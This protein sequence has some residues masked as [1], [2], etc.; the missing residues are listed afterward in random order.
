VKDLKYVL[1]SNPFLKRGLFVFVAVV[2]LTVGVLAY[3]ARGHISSKDLH[4]KI[5]AYERNG[6][7]T[8]GL[9]E[10]SKV[11]E[12]ALSIPDQEDLAWYRAGCYY[13]NQDFAKAHAQVTV[14]EDLY[15]RDTP[16][17]ADQERLVEYKKNLTLDETT[18]KTQAETNQRIEQDL[19]NGKKDTYNGP[20]L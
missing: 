12:E 18:I 2:A 8:H 17:T 19:K 3:N 7:C 5:T 6:D 11:R 15:H 13:Q 16:A 9:K 14:L 1:G 10:F 4:A 20:L